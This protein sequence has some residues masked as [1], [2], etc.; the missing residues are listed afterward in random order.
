MKRKLMLL[1]ACLFVGIG[2]VTAQTQ[3]VTGVVISEEDG[4][5]VVG[6]SVLVK[7]TT[8]GTITDVDGNFN[9]SNVPSSAKT[10]QISYIGM[11]TQEVVIKPNLR[12]VLKADAQKLDEVVVTAMGISREKKA[13]GY[14]VQ[15]VKSD[16]LTRAAN[17]DLAGALQG[18]VSGI[19]ITPSSGM[20]GASS[21]I[22]IRGSRSFTGDNT[23]LYVID[24][25][26]IASTADVSTSLTDGAYGTDYANRAVDIDPN[27]I[28]SINILKGQAASAL[29]GMRASNGVIVITT[30]S[31]KGADKG[32]PTITFST[33]LSFDKIS[34]LP[35]LQQEYAQGSGGTFDPSSPFAW[36]PKISELANDPT[37]G[38]NTDNSYTS[39]YGKQSGKYYVPQLAAAGMNPW[40]TPQAYNNMKDFFETGVSWSNNVN[41]AQRFDKGNYSFSLGNT[42]SNGIVPSTGMDRYN[43]KMSAEAQLHPNWTTG[44]NGNFVT[45][46]I[47]KQSTANTSV[48]ATIYNAPVSY[49]MAG[50]PSHIEGDP[51]TQNTYR[52]SWID[53][54]YW[55]VDNNQFS[56]RSQRFFGNAFVKYTTKFGTD[57]HKLDIKYQI[58]DD[59]YTTNYSEIYGYGSTWAPTGEDSEYH[60]T[61]NELNSLLTA[62]YT[63][64]INEEWTLDALIGNEFV[65]KKTKYEYAYSMNFNF[66]GWNHLNNASVFSNESQYNKKRTVGNFA[67]LSVAWKNMLYLSGSIRNDIV[68]SMPR[69]N[70]S[71]TYPSVSLGF[72]FTELAPLKNNILTFGKIRASYAEVGMAGDYT[73]SYYYTPSY[74]G[75]FY[76]GNPIVYPINGAMAY[77]PYYKVYDPNLKPQNTKSYELGADLTFLNGLVTL[78]YT[79][80]RQNVKDQIFEVPLAGSTGASSMI[81]NGGKIHTNTHELTLGV[82]PVDTKN[83]KLDFAFN[84]SKIDNYVDELAPG[85]ESIM[86]GGFVTPQVRAG[87]GDK[88]P[89]IYGK[90]YM[91]NDEGKIVVD[92]NGLPMQGE[93]AVIGTVS[94]DFRLGFNTNI[95]LYKFR[96]SAVFDWKQGGQMYSGTAGEM[97]YYGVSKLS[98]DMRNTEFIVEN[99]VKETGKDADGNSIYAPNDIK[100]TDAQAYFTRRRSID[101]SYIY[102]N[103]YIKLRELSVSYP[104]FSKK[105]LNVNVNV[106]ARNILVWS[107]MKGFDPEA[108]QGN[109]NMGGAFERFS[110]PGTASYG[111]GFNVKF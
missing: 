20:P 29:Y 102:D 2:L 42:T 46:K 69:D 8:L 94:P 72:I 103:S 47:S 108:S 34:T 61:V 90:S 111:F 62:A 107:E 109:D 80:S 74:G 49:N 6:A 101:E 95:E 19:D 77:I 92:K 10:L 15:D 76:M 32:K 48:V 7:G 81:M 73:Q 66:P 28:E 40:A 58:G 106:F 39:Q 104:V 71:F 3:K 36:G 57:N 63:W 79:Y 45:S 35:E 64:N 70:R 55:A 99:S 18:K 105:W 33:N 23:P 27:D 25:M 30:K 12:V 91:R 37:Y 86:L 52:D 21:K 83:F 67:N 60:Y 13:L 65:D 50:I 84:F 44:F 11:Q 96:I 75:G 24:G 97:N 68:S 4:Q 93:D 100:V 43:V 16:A 56:E 14:A 98:G 1:L 22:T 17:T 51:Y 5:P 110:L 85:V 54:A 59:A 53:D 41:V 78:N 87:I 26:P 31:G 89:V 9:L 82:S 88:F 38:G